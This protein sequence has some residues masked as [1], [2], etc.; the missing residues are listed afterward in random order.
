MSKKL[1]EYSIFI[2]D[3]TQFNQIKNTYNRD[4][5]VSSN[6]IKCDRPV[7]TSLRF[8]T[9]PYVCKSCRTGKEVY[10]RKE[11]L[12]NH[13]V[14]SLVGNQI[15][16]ECKNCNTPIETTLKAFDHKVQK[17]KYF[18]CKACIDLKLHDKRSKAQ[19]SS[20]NTMRGKHYS[21]EK[22]A[23]RLTK[24]KET[25]I[26]KYGSVE[27]Y[28]SHMSEKSK[29]SYKNYTSE[30]KKEIVNTRKVTCIEKYGVDNPMKIKEVSQKVVDNTDYEKRNEITLNTICSKYGSLENYYRILKE[31]IKEGN[32]R[33]FGVDWSFQAEEVKEK[34]RKTL[35][36]KYGVD[37]FSKTEEFHKMLPSIMKE[38]N[39]R[40]LY[41]NIYF[42]SSWELAYFIWL[43]DNKVSF[44][45]KPSPLIYIING[46]EHRYFPDFKVGDTYVE[47]KGD[48]LFNESGDLGVFAKEYDSAK[49]K[50]LKDNNIE[51][52]GSTRIK[53]Y[54]NY[55]KDLYGKDYLKSFRT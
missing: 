8:F 46:E 13:N 31:K 37:N 7:N 2:K 54:L 55:V 18:Y 12:L 30:R 23:E 9:Y 45:F 28:K 21:E 42:D 24:R 40:Y 15:K 50:F 25:L 17:Y 49:F 5:R 52:I 39:K 35:I 53:I 26:E 38:S 14:I 22:Q 48:Q 33:H 43:Q 51:I 16:V 20:N 3:E 29:D 11:A 1:V 19:L 34:I 36:E 4:Q 10:S 47:I 6:C 27:A 41:N 32:N 44:E